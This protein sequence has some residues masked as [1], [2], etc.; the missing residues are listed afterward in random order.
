MFGDLLKLEGSCV[1]MGKVVFLV[2]RRF[3]RRMLLDI[4]EIFW[5][6]VLWIGGLVMCV[7]LI[8]LYLIYYMRDSFFVVEY[9]FCSVWFVWYGVNKGI[10]CRCGKSRWKLLVK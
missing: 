5:R 7:R 10:V 6:L 1:G 8:L 3:G 9:I 2:Y 4:E